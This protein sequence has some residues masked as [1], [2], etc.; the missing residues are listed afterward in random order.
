M[1]SSR[2]QHQ[3]ADCRDVEAMTGMEDSTAPLERQVSL[4]W[5]LKLHD[6]CITERREMA[7]TTEN[8]L[9]GDCV[10]S[11]LERIRKQVADYEASGG[12]EG[13]RC[14]QIAEIMN[15][16][17]GTVM[18]RLYRGRRRLRRLLTD[19]AE[20]TTTTAGPAASMSCISRNSA[21]PGTTHPE[22]AHPTQT[23]C[24][25]VGE[26]SQHVDRACPLRL[27]LRALL[28]APLQRT[29]IHPPGCAVRT[30]GWNR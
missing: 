2:R 15:T 22:L 11:P 27:S 16:P 29:G 5:F 26:G 3:V 6:G 19:T 9:D 23:E 24:T 13:L 7:L 1:A 4:N 14:R 10:P 25:H 18:S 30:A 8:G 12:V 28:V 20:D 21:K 17:D